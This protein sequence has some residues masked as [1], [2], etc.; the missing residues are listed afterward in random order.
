VTFRGLGVATLFVA[1]A[2]GGSGVLRIPKGFPA[3]VI[4]ADNP[5][6]AAKVRLGRYLFYDK[7][8]SVNGTISCATC[9]RQELAFTD[10]RDHAKGATGELHPRSAMTLV[11]VAWN[12]TFNWGDLSVHSLEEQAL[13]PMMSVKPVELGYSTIEKDFLEL[14]STD[15]LYRELFP[16]AFPNEPKPG[17]TAN[18]AKAI[19]SFER[20]IVSGGSPW[21]RFHFDGDAAAISESAKRGEVLFFLDG[22]PSC[23]K[24]HSGFN[25]S[26]SVAFV[27]QEAVTA[28]F[29]NTGLYNLAGE[30]SY[31]DGG[32]GLYESSKRAEDMGKFKVPTLRNI[33][34]TAPYMHDG[35]A[36][37]LGDV[38]EHYASG[39]RTIASGPLAG[40]GHDNPLKDKLV[41]GFTMTARNKADMIAFLEA[42]TD[43][44]LLHD[45][46]LSDPWP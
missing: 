38:L 36:A 40:V 1:C 23:F 13:K 2:W 6:T 9:H 12:R 22:G 14:T 18:I 43:Q 19:A 24:C 45:P 26:D 46:E 44:G 33:A 11:N 34:L 21:D 41:H 8:M 17:T 28:P 20:T 16:A 39:G 32:R 31:P 35:S 7:R 37:T 30:F 5:L 3:P 42:L 27:G 10:G 25:F 29:H 15:P 4:P